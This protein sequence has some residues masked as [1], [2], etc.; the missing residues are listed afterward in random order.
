MTVNARKESGSLTVVL[1]GK[2]KVV[3]KTL[4]PGVVSGSNGIG[5]DEDGVKVRYLET[6]EVAGVNVCDIRMS[7]ALKRG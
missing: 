2:N 7:L 5:L 1:N 3:P 6:E 4:D